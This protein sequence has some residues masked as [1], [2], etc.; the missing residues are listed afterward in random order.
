MPL[1]DGAYGRFKVWEGLESGKVRVPLLKGRRQAD[2][3]QMDPGGY[4]VE[5]I[6]SNQ[7]RV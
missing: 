4:G 5:V 1:P 6:P 7:M 2:D 3:A